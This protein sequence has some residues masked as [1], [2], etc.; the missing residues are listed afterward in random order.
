MHIND[1]LTHRKLPAWREKFNSLVDRRGPDDCWE[2]QGTFEVTGYGLMSLGKTQRTHRLAWMFAN[3][4]IPYKSGPRGYCI[5]HSCDNRACC[6][7]AHLWLGTDRDNALDATHKGRMAQG[8]GH[9]AA[10]LTEE[11]V[12][13]IRCDTRPVRVI[14]A[15]L[16]IS[17]STIYGAQR[18]TGWKKVDAAPLTGT[19][20]KITLRGA[21]ANSAKLT[22]DQVYAIRADGRSAR[23]IAEN[24]G[25]RPENVYAI[26]KRKSWTHLPVRPE[27]VGTGG[28][29]GR[30]RAP[31]YVPPQPKKLA[32]LRRAVEALIASREEMDEGWFIPTEAMTALDAAMKK[33]TTE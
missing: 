27:D 32:L 25:I 3:G 21:N 23:A 11:R 15:E 33:G 31:G 13:A 9:H 28:T 12:A 30:P 1:I 10:K 17:T 2:W 8:S 20:E 6:N 18:G 29:R 22:E 14:A 24:H 5:C 4:P 26:K 7:P 16:G 19:R